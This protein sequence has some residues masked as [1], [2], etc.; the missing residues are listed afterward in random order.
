MVQFFDRKDDL[1]YVRWSSE[2]K[3]RDFY[4]CILCGRKGVALNSHHLNG[5]AGF[6]T[7]RYDVS[8][9]VTLCTFHHEDFHKH[10]GKG[11][12]TAEQFE[13][14]RAIAEVMIKVANEEAIINSA[15][16]RILQ[17]A[18]KD[19]A[20]KEVLDDLKERYGSDKDGYDNEY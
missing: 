20:V 5:W 6:P 4:T 16:R 11:N 9:G 18:E 13:E 19:K 12:N 10:F 8:N 17:Q 3:R 7:E 2:V 15:T 1:S 14:Y